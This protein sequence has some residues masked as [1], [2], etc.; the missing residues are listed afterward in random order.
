MSL[1]KN[2][3]KYIH[4]FTAKKHRKEEKAFV[5]EGYKSVDE[6]LHAGFKAKLLIATVEWIPKV[7]LPSDTEYITATKEELR[8]ASLLQNPQQVIGVFSFA[9]N[10]ASELQQLPSTELCLCLDGIQDPGNLGT[11]IRTADWFGIKHIFCSNNTVDAYN[12]KVVQATMGSI[13]RVNINYLD[14]PCFLQSL[15]RDIPIYG[16][17]LDG[18]NLYS[19]ELK[20]TGIVVMGNEGNGISPEVQEF[21]THRILIPS[22]NP[23]QPTAESLNVSIATAIMCAEFRRRNIKK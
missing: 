13:A 21:V 4:N 20:Q 14:L 5:A 12:P 11:I 10:T 22:F 23:K 16:T 8:K 1:S 19:T 7:V 17:L 3:I 15:S 9:E 2:K 6:L 18:D